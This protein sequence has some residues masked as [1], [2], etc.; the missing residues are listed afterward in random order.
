MD[1]FAMQKEVSDW[2]NLKL[3]P[4]LEDALDKADSGATIKKIDR[5]EL[6]IDISSKPDWLAWLSTEITGQLQKR[7]RELSP[8]ADNDVQE[9]TVSQGFFE[10]LFYF[11][12]NGFLP[13]WGSFRNKTEFSAAFL[14]TVKEG[15]SPE[16]KTRLLRV[17][18]D[19]QARDRLVDQ[20][21]EGEW[22]LLISE[23]YT[24]QTREL[25]LLVADT[26]ALLAILPQDKRRE[27][28]KEFIAN[29][30]KH[31]GD[32][33]QR[34]ALQEIAMAFTKSI[35]SFIDSATEL[36]YNKIKP[37]STIMEDAIVTT[38]KESKETGFRK[39]IGKEQV[40]QAADADDLIRKTKDQNRLS[41]LAATD[42]IY[43]NNAGLI[44]LAPF[45]PAFFIKLG[46]ANEDMILD[47]Q[48]AVNLAAYLVT[49]TEYAA[50]FELVLAKIL[51][52]IEPS[53][54]IS[55][56]IAFTEEQKKESQELLLS[57]IEYWDM[58]KDT[59]PQGLR[60]S[61]LQ[62]EGKLSFIDGEWILQV[63]QKPFDMLLQSL[64]WNISMIK[65]PWMSSILKTEWVY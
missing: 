51:C 30:W 50:E 10:S 5:I 8:A 3:A 18:A 62:R 19:N 42:A 1:G 47:K 6:E 41:E 48:A 44:I 7:L 31:A 49:G 21:H 64:P 35:Y 27:I 26:I 24:D 34:T 17:I 37:S 29:T 43:I 22:L 39:V 60:E 20:L 58:L 11:L 2:C 54:Q 40:E 52:G 57:A 46:L 63:E 55:T 4:G 65:L 9:Q 59:S 25:H 38:E 56:L 28:K 45:F 32:I 14:A 36:E 53:E 61:F 23:F 16:V 15:V 12:Q 33:D 13:W